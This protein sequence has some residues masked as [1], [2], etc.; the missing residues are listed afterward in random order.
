[1][2]VLSMTQITELKL[3]LDIGRQGHRFYDFVLTLLIACISLEIFVGIIIIY[4]GNLHY[5]QARKRKG[6]CRSFLAC[7]WCCCRACTRYSSKRNGIYLSVRATTAGGGSERARQPL[8]QDEDEEPNG[9]CDWTQ[10]EPRMETI[11]DLERADSNIEIAKVKVADADVKIVRSSNY[12]KVVE[13]ALKKSP[14]NSDLE[15][16]LHKAKEEMHS[17]AREKEEAEADQKL[18]EAQ[19]H[20]AF[21]IKE[22]WEDRE[23][24]VVYRKGTFWQH[25][26]TY[27]LYFIGLMNVF[28]TTFG[29][30]GSFHGSVIGYNATLT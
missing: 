28:I 10:R 29:I 25:C 20:Q 8:T 23:E 5:N 14:G 7:F 27:L 3:L 24:R 15:E 21:F 12:I 22:Q 26:A 4:I 6:I 18:A 16:E 13:D 1:M 2:S 19:Q 11:I 9:C 30:S 17:A